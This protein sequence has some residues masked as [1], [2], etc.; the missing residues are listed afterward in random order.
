VAC[1][2]SKSFEV[3]PAFGLGIGLEGLEGEAQ[4]RHFKAATPA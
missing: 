4:R 2:G 3:L 1:A